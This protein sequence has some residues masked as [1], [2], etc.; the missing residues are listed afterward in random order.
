MISQL[1]YLDGKWVRGSNILRAHALYLN[2]T[3]DLLSGKSHSSTVDNVLTS[4]LGNSFSE[5]SEKAK[6][7]HLFYELGTL[8]NSSEVDEE[9]LLAIFLEFEG[10]EEYHPTGPDFSFKPLSAPSEAQYQV[11]FKTGYEHLLRG[12]CYQFN[13]TYP[14]TFTST[15]EMNAK[16]FAHGLQ[17]PGAFAH[18]ADISSLGIS[19]LS[20]SP[21][22]LFEREGKN[23][24][25]TKPIKGTIKKSPGA[26]RELLT[27]KKDLAEL[28]MITDLLRNDLN[29]IDRPEAKLRARSKLLEVAHLYHLYSEISIDLDS[30]VTLKDV[31]LSL[32][33]SGSVTGA[34]KKRVMEILLGLE[35]EKRGLYCGTTLFSYGD[36]LRANV[37][38]RSGIVDH[39]KNIFTY[40]AG[41][42]CTLLSQAHTEYAEMLDKV[43]SFTS[44]FF[45]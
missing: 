6:V 29:R 10:I 3:T 14:F 30:K 40:H 42:G 43:H 12:D 34:P 4:W 39:S 11:A 19:L 15:I 13:L 25:V 35:R 37:N 18:A 16:H 33:P 32:F 8:L 24:L 20:N 7:I 45:R 2:Q 31:V 17:N 38:I 41:G 9:A 44:S 21:E 26:E 23:V 22:S 1:L 27:S 5:K 36:I 28:D